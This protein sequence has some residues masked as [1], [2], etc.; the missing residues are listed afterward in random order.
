MKYIV[1]GGAGF[2]GSHLVD[3]LIE[4]G[5]RV[6]IIDNE[7]STTTDT[8]YWNEK[9]EHYFADVTDYL[10]TSQLYA[11]ADC[12]FHFAGQSSVRASNRHTART[13]YSDIYGTSVVLQCAKDNNVKRFV[14]ASSAAVY[15]NGELPNTETQSDDS[16]NLYAVSKLAAEKLC[17][18]YHKIFGLE[19]VILRLFNVYGERQPKNGEFPSLLGNFENQKAKQF[20]LTIFGDG[21]QRRDFIHVSDA[22]D[23]IVLAATTELENEFIGTP[24]NIGYGK[25]YSVNE[26][27]KMFKHYFINTPQN[28]IDAYKS[29]SD[30]I[31]NKANI[32][33]AKQVFGWQPKIDLKQWLD[34][35]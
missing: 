2:I 31:E 12:V 35:K 27:V 32:E 13:A 18:S 19:T 24:F 26:I 21:N 22:V 1:T 30:I 7:S 6:I 8:Y 4:L 33:K 34:Q 16:L 11:N 9:A 5:N 14:Y 28:E 15:G 17:Q 3:R 25:N 23:A 10:K 20:P 29:K